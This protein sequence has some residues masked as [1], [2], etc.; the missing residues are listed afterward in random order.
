MLNIL[1]HPIL[2]MVYTREVLN[3][4][5]KIEAQREFNIPGSQFAGTALEPLFRSLRQYEMSDKGSVITFIENLRQF[6]CELDGRLKGQTA[7][8]TDD[9]ST[10]LSL[11]RAFIRLYMGAL[12][13]LIIAIDHVGLPVSDDTIFHLID[14]AAASAM[15][16]FGGMAGNGVQVMGL[17]ETRCLDFDDLRILSANEGTL[18]P[19][20]NV[21]SFIPNRFRAAFNMPTIELSE[22]AQ[23]YRFYRLVS[24]AGVIT[25][26]R[27]TPDDTEPSRFIEQMARVYGIDV[28]HV[29]RT[30]SINITHAKLITIDSD[31]LRRRI[32]SKYTTGDAATAP[33]LS[34]SSIK[35]YLKC[36][37]K[38]YFHHIQG[39][40]D[41]NEASD[42][43]DSGEFGTIVHDTLQELYYPTLSP[44]VARKREFNK[45]D[46][47]NFRKN[48]LDTALTRQINKTFNHTGEDNHDALTGQGIILKQTLRTYV[49]RALDIDCAAIADNGSLEVVECET[50]HPLKL[51]LTDEVSVN[52]TFKADRIDRIGSTLRIID[53]KTGK[54]DVKF[55]AV[56]ELFTEKS[57]NKQVVLQLL[58]YCMSYVQ[59]GQ[60]PRGITHIQPVVYKLSASHDNVGV[61]MGRGKGKEQLTI[62]VQDFLNHP[63][64]STFAIEMTKHLKPLWTSPIAQTTDSENCK[65]CNFKDFCR[66]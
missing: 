43:M 52:F 36:P 25:L 60:V 18:P 16:P 12:D 11:Q 24:R 55:N 1:S 30:A 66:R 13:Q 56:E 41:D 26:Y 58:L 23:T 8:I 34:A 2:K 29:T 62:P 22:A 61:K 6:C 50:Q 57:H 48:G 65:Y 20:N 64:V 15:I 14:R 40:S 59:L 7:V 42:F 53:Y 44:G 46:I 51:R 9:T 35:E 3:L 10:T 31:S 63:V 39:L 4:N 19:R 38:F 17:L 28:H 37:L 54:D 47:E 45:G 49:E 5:N 32:F 33:C 27:N 21:Q